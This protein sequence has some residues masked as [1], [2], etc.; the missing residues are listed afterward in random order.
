MRRRWNDPEHVNDYV[1]SLIKNDKGLIEFIKHFLSD[2]R[3]HGM[4][5]YVESVSWR[6]NLESV[7]TFVE[8]DEVDK[9]LRK[10]QSQPQYND[11]E[12]KGKLAIKTFLDTRDGK[13]K[14]R[15]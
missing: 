8:L 11:L 10:I 6:I 3:S 15:F 12:D 2:V 7:E 9:R 1:Q 13:I 5:D 4:T 14:D